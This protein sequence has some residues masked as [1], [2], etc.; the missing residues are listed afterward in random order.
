MYMRGYGARVTKP[1]PRIKRGKKIE[2]HME[3]LLFYLYRFIILSGN[4]LT[5]REREKGRK[6]THGSGP[7]AEGFFCV[8]QASFFLRKTSGLKDSWRCSWTSNVGPL[9]TLRS[10]FSQSVPTRCTLKITQT[11]N[12]RMSLGR[13]VRGKN[14][15]EQ[16]T[17]DS[18]DNARH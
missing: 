12:F 7:T 3:V 6:G 8:V 15:H 16:A 9:K 14:T 11:C 18:D 1:Q 10:G 4:P 5:E 17:Q 13:H 2:K